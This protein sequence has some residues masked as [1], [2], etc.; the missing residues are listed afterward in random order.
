M[1]LD[2]WCLVHGGH[3]WAPVR[4]D[5]WL[6]A[7]HSHATVRLLRFEECV[8]CRITRATITAPEPEDAR[9]VIP[10]RSYFGE[11]QRGIA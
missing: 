2:L 10:E 1:Q 7:D 5:Q 9:L 3:A 8:H 11:K 6:P 4:E